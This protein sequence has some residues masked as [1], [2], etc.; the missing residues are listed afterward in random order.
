MRFLE[1][2]GFG[3]EGALR[4]WLLPSGWSDAGADS[5]PGF[6]LLL[7]AVSRK[8]GVPIAELRTGAE[9]LMPPEARSSE[10]GPKD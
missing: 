8:T 1:N 10:S 7:L 4:A 6:S 5:D 9:L 3:H 2:Q